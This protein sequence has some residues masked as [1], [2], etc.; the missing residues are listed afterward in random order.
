MKYRNVLAASALLFAIIPLPVLATD[1]RVVSS[2]EETEIL[3]DIASYKN[4]EGSHH[5]AWFITTYN[6]T[7]RE[8]NDGPAF[9]V[10]FVHVFFRCMNATGPISKLILFA[11]EAAV[12]ARRPV[13]QFDYPVIWRPVD[14][15]TD[16][17]LMWRYVC[18]KGW[19]RD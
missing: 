5:E 18:T 12:K 16:V 11:D 14:I 8:S 3:M 10:S 2:N 15:K 13:A 19:E 7:Q 6:K 1:L 17:G 4:V 9:R